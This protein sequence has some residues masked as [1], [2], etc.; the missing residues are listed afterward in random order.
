MKILFIMAWR[1]LWQNKRRTY[2]TATSVVLALVLALFMRSM[3]FGSYETMIRAGVNE[4]GNMQVHDTGYWD[5]KTI[6]RAFF[7]N[8]ALEQKISS[9][10]GV[11]HMLPHLETFVLASY[12]DKTKGVQLVGVNPEAEDLQVKISGKITS[13][14]YLIKGQAGLVIGDKIAEYLNI[15]IGDSLVVMGQGYEGTTAVGIYPVTGI[16]HY[17]SPQ[18]NN[19]IVYMDL[20]TLQKLIFPFRPGLLTGISVY[21]EPGLE[22]Q[23][24]STI[25]TSVGDHFE[26]ISWKV[27]LSDMLQ[28]IKLDNLSGMVMLMILYIIVAFGIFSTVLMMTVERRRQFAVMISIGMRKGKLVITSIFESIF[29]ALIGVVA[30][31]IL[32]TPALMYFYLNP[33]RMTGEM[34]AMYE[35]F[36]QEPLMAFSIAPSIFFSQSL[37]VLSLALLSALYPIFYVL[38]FN[39]LNALRQ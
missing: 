7:T 8:P 33:I 4:V 28:S 12:G 27:M 1:N 30:G 31:L 11:I 37:I 15:N 24:L 22:D 18:M 20:E 39:V 10:P 9:L 16:A 29:I 19:L 6:D 26:V 25:K 2:I 23:L 13:G 34:A 17:V 32:T 5:N 21:C 35:S 36:N 38:R 14:S 3:Q